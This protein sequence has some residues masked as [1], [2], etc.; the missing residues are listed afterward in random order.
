MK[1]DRD[2][3]KNLM[4]TGKAQWY[5]IKNLSIDEAEVRIYDEI[6]LWGVTAE[7]FVNELDKLDVGKLTVRIN[8][9]GGNVFDGIAIHNALLSHRAEVTMVVDSLAASAA[10]FI[11]QAGDKRKMMK[12]S[13]MMVHNAQGVAIGDAKSMR[14][15][16]ELLEQQNDVIAGIYADRSGKDKADF[17]ALMAD[18]KFMTAEQA[19]EHGLADEIISNDRNETS[20]EIGNQIGGSPNVSVDWSSLFTMDLEDML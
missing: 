7:D 1:L 13:Q 4:P 12:H 18:A 9:P 17:R 2:A 6:S 19:V 20:N 15:M 8:S 11:V 14:E 3:I 16:A 5:E 10:S